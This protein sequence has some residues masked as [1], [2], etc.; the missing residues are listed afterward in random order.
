LVCRPSRPQT[1]YFG[2]LTESDRPPEGSQPARRSACR[3]WPR[4]RSRIH[5]GHGFRR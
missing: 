4:G 5:C 2:R 1:P 3:S